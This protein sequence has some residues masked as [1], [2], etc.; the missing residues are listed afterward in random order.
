MNSVVYSKALLSD[1]AELT[2]NQENIHPMV[3]NRIRSDTQLTMAQME[4]ILG[5]T[6][7][8]AITPA[9]EIIYTAA[10]MKTTAFTASPDSLTAQQFTKLADS[11]LSLE[12]HKNK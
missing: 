2:G 5:H 6:P 1:L 8:I 12:K 4:E 3:V 11:I 7:L 9:P 10:R